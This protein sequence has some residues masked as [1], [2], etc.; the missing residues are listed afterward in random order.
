VI[1]GSNR[2]I[3]LIS[4]LWI[5]GLLAVMAASFASTIRTTAPPHPNSHGEVQ[6]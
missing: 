3:A 6:G 1:V 2:G 4:V 5:T